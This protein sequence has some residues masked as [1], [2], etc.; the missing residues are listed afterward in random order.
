[1]VLFR[2]K[3]VGVCCA[4]FILS[5][6]VAAR[7]KEPSGQDERP[8]VILIMLDD[9]GWADLSCYGSK[10][11]KSPH[12]DRLATEGMR[13]TQAYAA[14]PVCSPTRAA[15]MTGRSPARLHIT[16]WLPGGF[17][18]PANRMAK[19]LTTWELP[20]S[21]I[22]LAEKL[23]AAGYVTGHV[24]KW[25]LGGKGFG[26]RNQGFDLNV[27]GDEK[28]T[29]RGYFAP[30]CERNGADVPHLDWAPPGTYL[31]DIFNQAALRFIREHRE[32]PFF[33]YLPHFAVHAPLQA[34]PQK[35][36]K[37]KKVKEE[38]EQANPVYAAMIESV[39]DG[40]S[41]IVK[42]LDKLKLTKKTILIFT[43]DNGGV[44]TADWPTKP[45][46][47][48]GALRE[49]KGHLYEGGIRVPLI[50]RWPGKIASGSIC[51]TPVT[52]EDFFPTILEMC[53]VEKEPLVDL[54]DHQEKLSVA[55]FE[56]ET[57]LAAAA[58]ESPLDGVSMV[59]LLRQTGS[60]QRAALYWHF[61]H[62]SPQHGR[63]CGAIRSGDY[64]LIVFYED[65]RRELYNLRRD[66]G[67]TNNL[68]DQEKEKVRELGAK[69]SAWRRSVGAQM[70]YPNPFYR[71]NP[72]QTD[73]IVSLHARTADIHGSML[74]FQSPPHL[75]SLGYWGKQEDW[76]SFEFE[77]TKT[78]KF[79]V[80]M[81]YCC[82]KE[83]AGSKLEL[84]VGGQKLS[85][86]VQETGEKKF[87]P[88]VIGS[89]DLTRAGRHYLSIKPQSKPG[90]LVMDLRRVRL[91]PLK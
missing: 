91:L 41:Q 51:E 81:L 20:L 48:N 86:I 28:G 69:F 22:T 49:G 87:K 39:D 38:G 64:K 58:K 68:V 72:Q 78:G 30:F 23:R 6:G 3:L 21:E 31:T 56:A 9:L 10:Y 8:N 53:G 75:D 71:P 7:G 27:G 15:L 24:G 89:V 70:N 33:L 18:L 80:E 73:G 77:L 55:K 29:P 44:A 63:P 46:T 2:E 54:L 19:P 83:D 84:S 32:K 59:P 12:I 40:I 85:Q 42:E 66:P 13:F 50:V 76:A 35:V 79:D 67:E 5:V 65:H 26:P 90:N 17:D 47:V 4:F 45:S 62:Y 52:T 82:K 57:V 43:S 60:F 88:L 37:Y 61:P 36:V 11:H 74:R 25:H 1:M 34:K 14:A 16:D